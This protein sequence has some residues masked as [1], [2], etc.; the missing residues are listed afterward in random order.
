MTRQD[1]LD[2]V[3]G[4]WLGLPAGQSPPRLPDELAALLL[5]DEERRSA[6]R[7]PWGCWEFPFSD[8]FQ[9]GR[10][11][12]PEIDAWLAGQRARLAADG[13]RLEP[14]WPDGH[15]FALAVSHDVDDLSH[16]VTPGQWLRSARL[17]MGADGWRARLKA[18]L[19]TVP[20]SL[21]QVRLLSRAPDLAAS[22]ERALA[23]ETELGVRA[24]WFFTVWPCAKPHP[25]DCVYR[26][27]DPCRFE[28]RVRPVGEVV[29]AIAERGHEVGLHGSFA[30]ALE[31]GLLA[32]QAQTLARASGRPVRAT[33]Q[34]WLH[35]RIDHTPALQQA[36][37]LEVDGTLGFNDG[38]GF[39]AG[40]SLP[41]PLWDES[42]QREV[43]VLAL[44]LAVMDV[45]L[46]RPGAL[47]L[48]LALALS[49]SDRLVGRVAELGGLVSLLIHPSHLAEPRVESLFR[50]VVAKARAQGAWTATHGEILD[51]WTRRAAALGY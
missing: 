20:A 35:W 47:G 31:P 10:L 45:A 2:R 33:R 3:V 40:T 8:N 29:R 4:L 46:F 44:P 30:S 16:Q 6:H 11:F 26:L 39:R 27:D 15:A 43:G 42:R 51:H 28:G 7:D 23:I 50:H 9:R 22:V 1:H 5:R 17:R 32:D 14:L 13:V 49:L 34:H 36:A 25:V 48:D 24:S 41:V 37:G 18:A 38:V 19:A 21:W 12:E